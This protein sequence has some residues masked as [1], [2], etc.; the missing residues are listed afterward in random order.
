V[1]EEEKDCVIHSECF[2]LR[3]KCSRELF[4][5]QKMRGRIYV[6]SLTRCG[7][8]L[9]A[10]LISAKSFSEIGGLDEKIVAFQEWDTAIRLASNLSFHL[11]AGANIH[12]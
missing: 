12:L 4:G 11:C 2:G 1:A 6:D 3:K 8:M 9:Q 5:I 10:M 7:P